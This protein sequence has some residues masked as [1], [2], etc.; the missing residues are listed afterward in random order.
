MKYPTI[1]RFFWT[2]ATLVAAAWAQSAPAFAP[3]VSY[4]APGASA[5]AS[6]DFNG[7][8]KVD[9]V[10]ANGITTGS[11]G[12]SILVS[13]GDGS[14]QVPRNFATGTDP[15]AIAV[16]DFNGDGKLDVAV[17]NRASNS[18]SILLGNGDGTLQPASTI[19]LT[20]SPI[21]INTA[22]FNNDGKKDLVA[23]VNV[24]P[25]VYQAA[26]LMSNGDGTFGLTTMSAGSSLVVGDFNGD[27]RQDL[28]VFGLVVSPNA[29]IKYGNGDGTFTDSAVPFAT[30]VNAPFMVQN[31]VAGDFNGDG[32]LDL[33]GEIVSFRINSGIGF[34][35]LIALNNGD[36][37]FTVSFAGRGTLGAQNL[38]VGDFNRDGHLDI[39]G[40]GPGPVYTNVIPRPA[41]F[42]NVAY[43]NGDG[44]FAAA[45]S[46]PSGPSTS[47]FTSTPLVSADFDGNGS[48][49]FAWAAG[50]TLNVVRSANGN[51]PLLTKLVFDKGLVQGGLTPV[52]ATVSLGD[53]APASGAVITLASS[54]AL[55][56]FFPAGAT[57]TIPAGSTS[58]TFA[59]A[60]NVVA[61][62][63]VV[64]ISASWNGVTV[65]SSFQVVAPVTIASLVMQPASF[66]AQPGATGY[67]IMTF[68]GPAPEN[69][70]LTASSSNPGLLPVQP[71]PASAPGTYTP[72]NPMTVQIPVGATSA[73]V[74]MTTATRLFA[75]TP[76][77]IT[78]SLAMNGVQQGPS[79]SGMVTLLGAT[80][81]VSILKAEYAAR[82][83]IWTIEATSTNPAAAIVVKT[84]AG[85]VLGNLPAVSPGRYKGQGFAVAPFT[86][87]VLQSTLG[88]SATSP[89]TQK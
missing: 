73:L 9:V 84:T 39:A 17:A 51:P 6:G 71:D 62:A 50:S 32:R 35:A 85:A 67:A 45:V 29:M 53:P 33:Y 66:I 69:I 60:T 28:A 25:G 4:P 8:G 74:Q 48:P 57:V 7:D 1:L 22:D 16:G 87:V 40:A 11:H 61:A 10:T 58:V 68:S 83:S 24:S 56:T 81:T 46:A 2:A 5:A 30:G 77:T 72:G 21:S 12:V 41:N 88:G 47:F 75:N 37:T 54:D 59:V 63:E 26:I 80:D 76:V 13:N 36:G 44:T 70:V 55:A 18:I 43:G 20:G 79:R 3:P 78:A 34:G 52:T 82:T 31:A 89:V 86:T 65:A 49:D 42:V 27:G 19:V 14:F 64:T 15:T 23:V 38:L